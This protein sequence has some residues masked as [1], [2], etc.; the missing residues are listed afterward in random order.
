ME[1]LSVDLDENFFF[2]VDGLRRPHR[3]GFKL[4]K[5]IY[6][7]FPH[8]LAGSCDEVALKIL[9]SMKKSKKLYLQEHDVSN[10]GLPVDVLYTITIDHEAF[11]SLNSEVSLGDFLKAYNLTLIELKSFYWEV[12]PN[13]DASTWQPIYWR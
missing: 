10:E 13:M 7:D 3:G 8:R 4:V 1:A 2:E 12:V 6:S 9:A 11:M 5:P